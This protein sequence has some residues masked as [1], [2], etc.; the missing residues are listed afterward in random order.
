MENSDSKS[1]TIKIL[2]IIKYVITLVIGALGG[3]NADA[4]GSLF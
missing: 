3:A 2:T 1:V 4:I